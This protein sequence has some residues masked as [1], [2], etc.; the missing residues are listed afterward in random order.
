MGLRLRP[1]LLLSARR[2]GVPRPFN[3]AGL[4]C[5]DA[6]ERSPLI[7]RSIDR[8]CIAALAQAGQR[9]AGRVGEPARRSD[10]FLNGRAMIALKQ[11]N[12]TSQLRAAAWSRW[13]CRT[14]L[15]RF[16][17]SSVLGVQL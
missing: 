10:Q 1:A 2:L 3:E 11:R 12:N 13:A 6:V 15:H 9:G 8:D 16:C 14:R 7:V 4:T 17:G 5:R